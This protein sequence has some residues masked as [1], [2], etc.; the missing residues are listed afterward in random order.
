MRRENCL[1]NCE[2]IFHISPFEPL[3]STKSLHCVCRKTASSSG[4]GIVLLGVAN[5]CYLWKKNTFLLM[6]G[7]GF[8][9]LALICTSVVLEP[10]WFFGD[11][12]H[13]SCSVSPSRHAL[14]GMHCRECWE[15][16]GCRGGNCR[17]PA[18]GRWMVTLCSWPSAGEWLG[19]GE[20]LPG[21]FW[22][23]VL[24]W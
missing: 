1:D 9:Y 21:P 16:W 15:L 17:V 24:V 12:T 7:S 2:I 8:L 6:E 14:G 19:H 3:N 11:L 10:L 5:G 20:L 22:R 18:L 4:A 23:G 13:S